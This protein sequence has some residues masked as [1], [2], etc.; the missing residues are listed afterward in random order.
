M[1]VKNSTDAPLVPAVFPDRASAGAAVEALKQAGVDTT[2]IG[3]VVPVRETNRIGED[4][5]QAV[6]EGAAVGAALGARLG[7]VGGIVVA[8][9]LGPLGVGG[10][11]LAGASGLLWGGTVGGLIGVV[12]RV[13]RYP[14]TDS[15]CELGLD[16]KAVVVAVRVR[17]WADE[18]QIA[19]V[20]KQAGAKAVLD[21]MDL[22]HSWRELELEHRS[23]QAAPA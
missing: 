2:D 21:Q 6:L 17:D 22:D 14:N 18:P 23:G 20:L 4:S 3:V 1:V 13:R 8:A 19:S 7:V 10:L 12:T 11:F 5:E 15:W 16:D 9:A